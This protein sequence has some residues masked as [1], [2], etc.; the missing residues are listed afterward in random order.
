[1]SKTDGSVVLYF[2]RFLN[3]G[4]Q[5]N[6]GTVERLKPLA[7]QVVQVHDCIIDIF[8]DDFP[9]GLV[10]FSCKPSKPGALHLGSFITVSF[11]SCIVNGSSRQD[12]SC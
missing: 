2:L 4:D 1:M 10:E 11:I 12:K 8:L 7:V 9:A 6:M 5:H 3:F